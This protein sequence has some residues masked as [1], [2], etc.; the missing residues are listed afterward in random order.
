[1]DLK[2]LLQRKLSIVLILVFSS[3]LAL[4]ITVGQGIAN[5][6]KVLT[7]EPADVLG[8]KTSETPTPEVSKPFQCID[9]DT[10]TKFLK[11][12]QKTVTLYAPDKTVTLNMEPLKECFV[13][14]GCDADN[15]RCTSGVVTMNTQCLADYF[16]KY[17]LQVT[18]TKI[19]SGEG[20]SVQVRVQD[21]MVNY[22]NLAEQLKGAVEKEVTYCQ[23]QGLE[24][25]TTANIDNIQ[26]V[27]TDDTPNV[28]GSF[29]TKPF[30]EIDASK[31]KLYFWNDG[32]Y[33]TFPIN[34]GARLP[35]EGIYSRK[36]IDLKKILEGIHA[37]FISR[38]TKATD[39]VIVHK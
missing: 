20:A 13:A 1:M 34:R 5:Y 9:S 3:F 32:I 7:A 23:V 19:L 4:A 29:T 24:E 17:P 37:D 25:Q 30:I 38:N 6:G 16:K 22:D 39:Y 33:Q 28:E 8:A 27:V 2:S 36:A 11:E 12:T 35:K 15:F 26:L 31:E 18:E 21:W 14:T 10:F